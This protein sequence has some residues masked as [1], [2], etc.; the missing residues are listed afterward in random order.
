MRTEISGNS[1]TAEEGTFYLFGVRVD[2]TR[3][4]SAL[5]RVRR[6]ARERHGSRAREVF[7]A[8]VHSIRLARHNPGLRQCINHADLVLA[9][10]SGLG[11]AGKLFGTPIIENLNGTDFTPKEIGRAHV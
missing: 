6:Y 10:G 2:N 7:F 3:C 5:E 8:N 9:D 11:L 1:T 4:E